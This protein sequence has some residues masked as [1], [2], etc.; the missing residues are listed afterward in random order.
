MGDLIDITDVLKEKEELRLN[1]L[2][3]EQRLERLGQNALVSFNRFNEF[4]ENRSAN[5]IGKKYH[6]ASN[7]FIDEYKGG[8]FNMNTVLSAIAGELTSSFV[9]KNDKARLIDMIKPDIESIISVLLEDQLDLSLLIYEIES[10]NPVPNLILEKAE[11]LH[12][13]QKDI[14]SLYEVIAISLGCKFKF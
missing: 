8:V 2:S 12:F 3:E 6:F 10:M 14:I 13:L 4:L 7:E 11:K 1:K 5:E 9:D